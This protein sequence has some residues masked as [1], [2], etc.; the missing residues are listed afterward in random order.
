ME[1][2]PMTEQNTF[3]EVCKTFFCTFIFTHVTNKRASLLPI[4][5]ENYRNK[6]QRK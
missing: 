2:P 1:S 3:T 5:V 6:E 4:H